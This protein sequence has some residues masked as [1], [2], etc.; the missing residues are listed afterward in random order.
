MHLT[1]THTHL[2]YQAETGE[3]DGQMGRCLEHQITR[4][5]LPNVDVKSIDLIKKTIQSYPD[6]C[7][8]M[9]GLHPC[10][11]QSDY[12]AQ[13]QAIESRLHEFPVCAIGEIGL[14]LYWDKTTLAFQEE[15]FRIQVGWAKEMNLPIV[16]H[17]REAFD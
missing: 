8:A 5:F 15:A 13:L 12:L 9:L 1:D 10:S 11:V 14:D 2:Y 16:I 4:L 6:N 7:F 3:L 17:C